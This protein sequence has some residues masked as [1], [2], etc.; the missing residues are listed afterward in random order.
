MSP[1]YCYF[2]PHSDGV[3]N[4]SFLCVYEIDKLLFYGSDCDK[5]ISITEDV[6]QLNCQAMTLNNSED[7][8]SMKKTDQHLSSSNSL[9]S[10]GNGRI[11]ID[12]SRPAHATCVSVSV[13][14]QSENLSAHIPHRKSPFK[15]RGPSV[16]PGKE[17]ESQTP[18]HVVSPSVASTPRKRG[19]KPSTPSSL[20]CENL[21][22]NISSEDSNQTAQTEIM[23]F[24]LSKANGYKEVSWIRGSR[25]GMR[26]LIP[27]QDVVLLET[28]LLALG[29]KVTDDLSRSDWWAKEKCYLPPWSPLL[30][31]PTA[32][33]TAGIDIFWSLDDCLKYLLLFSNSPIP[34]SNSKKRIKSII[35]INLLEDSVDEYLQFLLE[36]PDPDSQIFFVW[37]YLKSTGWKIVEVPSELSIPVPVIAIPYWSS[38]S[39]KFTL[40]SFSKLKV[41]L[42]YFLYI[43]DAVC[44]LKVLL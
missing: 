27:P 23:E 4:L 33:I 21:A 34:Y 44:Y 8:S 6:L 39:K 41:N 24:L 10:P 36:V 2:L 20:L 29:W 3:E 22:K 14:R 26:R 17:V 31:D 30:Q 16:T 19:R 13:D 40:A 28:K 35:A 42:D 5:I 15:A 18:S 11:S 43:Q 7:K 32:N 9:S 12:T 37:K 1:G 38:H 25:Q